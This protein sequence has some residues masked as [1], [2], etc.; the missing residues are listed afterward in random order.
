MKPLALAL[1]ATAAA[2]AA[3]PALA[4]GRL[5]DVSLIDRESGARLPAHYHRGEYWVA[6]RPGA[7]YAIA[8]RNTRGERLLAVTSVDGINAISGETAGWDQ[9]GYVFGPWQGYEIAG[10]RKSDAQVAAF[11]FTAAPESYAA[12]TGRGA[13]IGVIGVALF[14]ERVPEPLRMPE[15]NA[16]PAPA[17]ERAAADGAG[18]AASAG[19]AL[20]AAP[21]AELAKS[22]AAAP[23][24]GTGHGA[25]EYS[26]V[27]RTDFERL[28]A[29]PDEIIRI[30]YDS[31][32]HLVAMGV[33]PRSRPLPPPMP[34]AFPDSPLTGYVPDPPER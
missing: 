21:S 1:L 7:R 4:I 23:R 27:E 22:A 24:L 25:R 18:A 30:R 5:A 31:E 17:S 28:H 12:R 33:I 19:T 13:S 34:E 6:G 14:R 20:P 3:A 26:Y 15:P 11:E 29:R 16:P 9:T 8:I 10:W 2:T 32:A